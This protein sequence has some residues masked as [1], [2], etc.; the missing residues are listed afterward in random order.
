MALSE[1]AHCRAG[2]L[3]PHSG[4]FSDVETYTLNYKLF[5]EGIAGSRS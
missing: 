2:P 4:Y 5:E 1:A 3:L